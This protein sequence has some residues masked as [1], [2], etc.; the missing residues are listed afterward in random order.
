MDRISAVLDPIIPRQTSLHCKAFDD[1]SGATRIVDTVAIEILTAESE[2][3]TKQVLQ[4]T[5]KAGRVILA[6][7][8]GP[9]V[10][11]QRRTYDLFGADNQIALRRPH[12]IRSKGAIAG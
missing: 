8:V 9:V 2:A 1:K 7:A 4:R 10:I 6:V 11:D 5:K 12:P 3:N